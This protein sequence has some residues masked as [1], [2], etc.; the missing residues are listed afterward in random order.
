MKKKEAQY[1]HCRKRFIR[2]VRM[3]FT[4]AM[5][6]QFVSKI[7]KAVFGNSGAVFLYR[8]SNRVTVW[9]IEHCGKIFKCVYDKNSKQIVTVL[10]CRIAAAENK[11]NTC[12][13]KSKPITSH[14]SLTGGRSEASEVG[15]S[16]WPSG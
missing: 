2:R 3:D 14:S 6:D 12:G 15:G 1:I 11:R 4:R 7:K 13:S 8:Q 5:N 10:G 9:D 16:C